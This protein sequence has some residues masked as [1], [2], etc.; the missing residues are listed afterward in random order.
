MSLLSWL[1]ELR[2]RLIVEFADRPRI[3]TLATVDDG[4]RP[5]ARSIVC[6]AIEDD[7]S[8]WMTSD[9]RSDKNKQLRENPFAELAIY[10]KGAREQFR[11]AGEMMVF[12]DGDQRHRAWHAQSDATRAMFFWDE[13]GAPVRAEF[14][15]PKE[16][17]AST[18]IP[19][20][21]EL[22]ILKPVRVEHLNLKP[23][24]PQR[25]VWSLDRDW[26]VESI[27]P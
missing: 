11:L 17:A 18:P 15:A 9:S 6:R 1:P 23:H 16:V 25:R 10:F 22:L 20:T 27:N 7:G 12:A 5:R 4:R 8:V 14:D 3:A 21:F 26:A 19:P 24:P 2:E 13:P